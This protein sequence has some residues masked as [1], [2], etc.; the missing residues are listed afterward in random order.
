MSSHSF[1]NN[2]LKCRVNEFKKIQFVIDESENV[3]LG[4]ATSIKKTSNEFFWKIC[5]WSYPRRF[6]PLQT[7]F[8]INH[9]NTRVYRNSFRCE[10]K[11]RLVLNFYKQQRPACER[12]IED[13]LSCKLSLFLWLLLSILVLFDTQSMGRYY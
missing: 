7:H 1:T 10:R 6:Y 3:L 5:V 8:K 9:M 12:Q 13:F 2:L 4:Q 11:L